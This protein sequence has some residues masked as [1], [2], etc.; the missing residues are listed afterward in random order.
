MCDPDDE[1]FKLILQAVN[2]CQWL[3]DIKDIYPSHDLIPEFLHMALLD[4]PHNA[5]SQLHLL[6]NEGSV[7]TLAILQHKI[8]TKKALHLC[9]QGSS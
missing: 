7:S 6:L 5:Q 4:D 1:M 2:G 3:Q 9:E 8:R